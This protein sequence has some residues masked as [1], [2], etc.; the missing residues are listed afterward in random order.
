VHDGT[1]SWRADAPGAQPTDEE[2]VRRVRAGDGD[3]ARLLFGRH[4]DALRMRV[5]RGLPRALRPKVAESDVIQ[6][7]YVAA[8]Q[9]LDEF[10]DR[11]DGSFARWIHVVVERKVLNE[12]RRHVGS[13]KRDARREVDAGASAEVAA[14]ASSDPSPSSAAEGAEERA[15]LTAA[16]TR[17]AAP[18]REV[19]QLVHQ[20]GLTYHEAAVRMDRSPEAVRKL[21]GRAVLALAELLRESEG[22]VS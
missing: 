22:T 11:G 6:D 14:G 18:F 1:P 5:R 8:F 21:Y 19:L 4:V 20:E 13:S 16:M 12:V 15:R 10:E 17:L 2:L 3:A 9:A 7:A